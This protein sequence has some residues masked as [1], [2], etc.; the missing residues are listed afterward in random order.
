MNRTEEYALLLQELD[1]L[2][3][4]LESVTE[5]AVKRKKTSQKKRC[6]LGIPTGSFAACFAGF[7]L[8]V[9]CFPTFAAACGSVP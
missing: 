9:N 7:V 8:L 6:L 5:R 1:N 3:I 2:P 4:E